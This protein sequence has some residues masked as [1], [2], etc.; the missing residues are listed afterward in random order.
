MIVKYRDVDVALV[1][2]GPYNLNTVVVEHLGLWPRSRVLEC[3]T[4]SG[5]TLTILKNQHI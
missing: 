3:E 4:A 2:Q 1:Q 5:M